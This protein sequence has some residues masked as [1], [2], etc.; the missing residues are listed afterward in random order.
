MSL[1]PI[2]IPD[3]ELFYAP[4]FL[5]PA[6]AVFLLKTLTADIAWE[7]HH[8]K[9]FGKEMLAPRLSAWYG[10]ADAT[11]AYSGFCHAPLAWTAPLKGLKKRVESAASTAFN[12][13][14]LN[15]Y[16]DGR[17]SM[18]WH[19]DDEPELGPAPSIASLSLGSERRFILRH[20]KRKDLDTVELPL[21]HGSL[22][23]MSGPTQSFW[24]HQ[25]PKTQR[26]VP[27]RLNLTFRRIIGP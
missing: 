23:V 6:D 3:G 17:D 1:N 5:A 21:K 18:G 10:D 25:I 15:H 27:S 11:Y 9:I 24:K 12:S 4:D 26:S 2:D 16:R 7:Q 22:L 14:L 13:V 19:S 20:K 8:V